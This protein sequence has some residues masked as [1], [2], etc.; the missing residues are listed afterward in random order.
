MREDTGDFRR[1]FLSGA[2]M[3]DVRAPLEFARGAFPGTV[4]LP[5]MDDEE[6][7]QVGLCY[8]QK[9][10]EAAIELGHDIVS[11]ELKAARIAAWAAFARAHP[12]GYLYCFR[13]G[14]RSQI[15]QRWLRDEAG[16]DYP[17][18]TGGYKAMRSFLID[19]TEQ[20]AATPE[21]FVLGGMTGTGKTDVIA[22]VPA[23]VDLEGLARH[24]GSAFGRR[25][26][27][28]PPQIDFENALAI[29][30][31]RRADA[32]YC[33]LVV[34]DEGRFIGG[35]DVPKALWQR[36]Q[37]S[38][39]V[40]LEAPF[41]ERVERALRDYVLGLAAEHIDQLGPVA[42]FEAYA[43]RLREAMAAIAP[44]LGGERYARLAAL[45]EQA[46]ASQSE[47]GDTGL[48]RG[49]IEVLLRDYYDPMYAYQQ[50]SRASRIVFRGDRAAVTGW[51]RERSAR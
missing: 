36:M 48:H 41:E 9:G 37:A 51:L 46:L 11:G 4:N 14:L 5:L 33:A 23:A 15:V 39:L 3:M 12:D 43:A 30:L 28:Q 29:D 16:I 18:V 44:R 26:L 24:R 35:R 47:H 7:H 45:L 32:G 2:P 34:E 25:A 42:G 31:L 40:W 38:P 17:R 22:D 49:W 10:Q 8:A 6:R 21:I 13:G 1:L 27:A 50:Q 20:A 19:V